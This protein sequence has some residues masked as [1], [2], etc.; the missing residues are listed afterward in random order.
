MQ[1]SFFDFIDQQERLLGQPGGLSYVRN[2]IPRDFH[3]LAEGYSY[4][5]T[6]GTKVDSVKA[7]YESRTNAIADLLKRS[8]EE[9]S[10][11]EAEDVTAYRK[12]RRTA[13]FAISG[14]ISQYRMVVGWLEYCGFVPNIPLIDRAAIKVRDQIFGESSG[15]TIEQFTK[16]LDNFETRLKAVEKGVRSGKADLIVAKELAAQQAQLRLL[17]QQLDSLNAFATRQLNAVHGMIVG[18]A[19]KADD[20]RELSKA[21][22]EQQRA[23]IY[24]K[25]AKKRKQIAAIRS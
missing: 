20:D 23:E 4:L 2:E 12:W 9:L 3:S 11:A 6:L 25:Y 10:D 5:C 22:I 19:D 17:G 7:Q 8:K 18:K 1:I 14:S 16:T 13:F 15:A 21:T 24:E